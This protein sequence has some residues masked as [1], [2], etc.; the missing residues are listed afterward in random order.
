MIRTTDSYFAAMYR[1]NN[2]DPW[3]YETSW[4]EQRKYALTLAALPREHYARGFEPGSSI[5]VLTE[6]LASRCDALVGLEL[7][8]S[9]AERARAR[10]GENTEVRVGRIPEEWPEGRFDLVV[11]SEVL[12]YLTEADIADVLA[13]LDGCMEP[14]GHV[15]AVHYRLE[16]DY[17]LS[18]DRVHALLDEHAW[19]NV[20]RYRE[21]AFA[22]DVYEAAEAPEAP[23][24]S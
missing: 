2:G 1:K 6:Q 20:G 14:G 12:Y 18:G 15:V 21:A 22:I 8:E 7:V 19:T 16:T 5:G 17:P 4:Y 11:L 23:E 9:V 13:R 3:G 24:A 10:V